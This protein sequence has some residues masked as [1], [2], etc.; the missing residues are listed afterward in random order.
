MAISAVLRDVLRDAD[1]VQ[2]LVAERVYR[3]E[4]PQSDPLPAIVVQLI[5]DPRPLTFSG[6]QSIRRAWLTI[7]CLA[8]SRGEADA[9]GERI[10]TEIDGRAL[11]ERPEVESTRIIDVR[12]DSSRANGGLATTFR[13]AI[14]VMVWHYP[15]N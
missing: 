2:S 1:A 15:S 10:V 6:P 3:D 11:V 4:R 13:T 14:D 9:I 5:S 7:E 8:A 12:N